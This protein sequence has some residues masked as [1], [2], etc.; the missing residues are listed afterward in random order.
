[1]EIGWKQTE[2]TSSLLNILYITFNYFELKKSNWLLLLDY[3]IYSAH[4]LV[5]FKT[6]L[7]T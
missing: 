7:P 5:I 2:I 3:Q 6:T 4:K 1:M